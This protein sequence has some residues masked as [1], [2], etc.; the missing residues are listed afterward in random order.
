MGTILSRTKDGVLVLN[1]G[2]GQVE[3]A[4]SKYFAMRG[5]GI[6]V[7]RHIRKPWAPSPAAPAQPA[8]PDPTKQTAEP[9][10]PRIPL[11]TMFHPLDPAQLELPGHLIHVARLD[12]QANPRAAWGKSIRRTAPVV[13]YS[14]LWG[15]LAIQP[16]K[17]MSSLLEEQAIR[18]E[19]PD[20]S[21]FNVLVL[22]RDLQ[23]PLDLSMVA[24][25]A[26]EIGHDFQ[27][28]KLY[29]VPDTE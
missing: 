18:M 11:P 22:G 3:L 8:Q 24:D 2:R 14:A 12:L 25:K 23:D 17:T 1:D 9:G 13:R 26:A 15:D 4:G 5:E 27:T 10:R 28:V 21:T 7:Y 29:Y 20:L 16:R 19:G 6:P